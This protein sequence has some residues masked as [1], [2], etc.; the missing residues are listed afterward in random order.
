MLLTRTTGQWKALTITQLN[1]ACKCT[2]CLPEGHFDKFFGCC[3]DQIAPSLYRKAFLTP[4]H[5]DTQVSWFFTHSPL[6]R[7]PLCPCLHISTKSDSVSEELKTPW[8]SKCQNQGLLFFQETGQGSRHCLTV[9]CAGTC[10]PTLARK[11]YRLNGCQ[12]IE[13]C[14]SNFKWL[15]SP[16]LLL[17][18]SPLLSRL[19]PNRLCLFLLHSLSCSL[20]VCL[21]LPAIFISH[22]ES[23]N[24]MKRKVKHLAGIRKH[25]CDNYVRVSCVRVSL[26]SRFIL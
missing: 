10:W 21:F 6:P 5:T 18:H 14:Q 3:E 8:T 26:E 7:L 4:D 24:L 15:L 22:S 1:C 25:P 13:D 11:R 9:A 17:F 19:L 2:E 16:S 23:V 20:S 12:V